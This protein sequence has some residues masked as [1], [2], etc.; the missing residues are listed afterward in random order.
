M[1][2]A[3]VMILNMGQHEAQ[4]TS[5]LAIVPTAIVG[6][7]IYAAYGNFNTTI[8][9]W[10]AIGGMAGS[11]GGSFLAGRIPEKTLKVIYSMFLIIVGVKMWF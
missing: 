2:P 10:L 1:V 5:L 8:A 3:M 4:G 6:A 9:I 7:L 11:Y